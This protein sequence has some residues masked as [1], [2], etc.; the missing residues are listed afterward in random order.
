MIVMSRSYRRADAAIHV[1]CSTSGPEQF[2]WRNRLYRVNQVLQQWERSAVWWKD[3]RTTPTG[4]DHQTWR[5]EASAGRCDAEGVYELSLDPASGQWY[6][7]RTF[8]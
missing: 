6:L 4:R 3:V 1:R 2:L 7:L 5:V 8:D